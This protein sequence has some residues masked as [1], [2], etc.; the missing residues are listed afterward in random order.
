VFNERQIHLTST[1]EGIDIGTT[2]DVVQQWWGGSTV[3][4]KEV[5]T[6]I[7]SLV[8]KPSKGQLTLLY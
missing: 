6:Q 3:E 7:I 5:M 1:H 2:F 8:S 4:P